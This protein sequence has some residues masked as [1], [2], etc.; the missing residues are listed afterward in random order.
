[1][2]ALLAELPHRHAVVL[3]G[4]KGAQLA[5]A[6][7]ADRACLGL[8]SSLTSTSMKEG[9]RSL[10]SFVLVL[11]VSL[12]GL[13]ALLNSRN[14]AVQFHVANFKRT[15]VGQSV[16]AFADTL[17]GAARHVVGQAVDVARPCAQH[18][19]GAMRPYAQQAVKVVRP[20]Y[21]QVATVA[22]DFGQEIM[23]RLEQT[24]R[25]VRQRLNLL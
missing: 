24:E 18:A 3:S 14:E 4:G 5:A 6:Q 22:A 16:S 20:L 12:L 25:L 8:S 11:V 10:G 1:M 15:S 13:L 21:E 23:W 9:A 17:T 19:A 2:K 7:A